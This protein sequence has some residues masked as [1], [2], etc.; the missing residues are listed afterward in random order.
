MTMY[1]L[2]LVNKWAK[3][4]LLWWKCY[5][6]IFILLST[7]TIG[8]K[9]RKWLGGKLKKVMYFHRKGKTLIIFVSRV[10]FTSILVLSYLCREVLF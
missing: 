8:T 5:L 3:G 2:Q 10:N 6:L 7:Y 9:Y 1:S 4:V